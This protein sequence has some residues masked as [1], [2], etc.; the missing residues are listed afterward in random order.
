MVILPLAVSSLG[1][2][3]NGVIIEHST[4]VV[5]L[6]DVDVEDGLDFFF[7]VD[8]GLSWL[9]STLFEVSFS[10]FTLL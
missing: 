8:I 4:N 9:L 7:K 6:D 1:N 3:E 5:V 2:F 10:L